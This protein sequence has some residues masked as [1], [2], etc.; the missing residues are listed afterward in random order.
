M[1]SEHTD[2]K[3]PKMYN[4]PETMFVLANEV[5]RQYLADAQQRRFAASARRARKARRR[6]RHRP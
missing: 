4:H 2:L 3:E 5:Q 6:S 1:R